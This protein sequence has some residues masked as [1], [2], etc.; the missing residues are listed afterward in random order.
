LENDG[1]DFYRWRL[2]RAIA[3]SIWVILIGGI[4][5]VDDLH[6]LSF[7]ETWPILLIAGGVLLLFKRALYGGYGPYAPGVYPGTPVT[8][9]AAAPVATTEI[10]PSGPVHGQTGDGQEGR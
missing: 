4:W 10:V 6:I 1:S 9:V 2:S 8:P 7:R 3:G 5:L